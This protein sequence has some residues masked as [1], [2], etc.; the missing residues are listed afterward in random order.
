MSIYIIGIGGTGAKCVEAIAQLAA[1]GL[2][3]E[4]PL[5]VLFIDADETNGN[6]NR[7]RSSL[8]SYQRCY[9]LVSG[10]DKQ[11]CPWMKTPI[12]SFDLWSPFAEQS[13]NKELKTFFNYNTLKQNQPTLGNLFDVLYTKEEREANLDVGFRGRPAIGSAVMSQVDLD[14]L[15]QEPWGRFIQQIQTDTSSGKNPKVFLCGSIFGGTGASGLPTI[16]RLI[17]NKLKK[18]NIRD[19]VQ[20][21]CLFALPYFGFSATPDEDPNGIYAR[22]EQFLLNTEAALRYYVTQGQVIFDT[23]YLLGN[24]NFSTVKFSIG[25]NDQCNDPH[26]I[27]LY[28]GLA[29]RQFLLKPP[30]Q[31]GAVVLISRKNMGHLTWNDIPEQGEV[32]PN[33]VNAT[34]FAYTW[35]AEIAPELANAKQ[36]GV[37]RFQRLA[38]WLTKFFRPAKSQANLP[39]FSDLKQQEAIG[40]I[41]NWCE[42][43]LRW[44]TEIHKCTGDSIELFNVSAFDDLNSELKGEELPNL[45]IGDNRDKSRKSQD[46]PKKIKERLNPSVV[47]PPNQG[48]VGLA[49]AVYL[50]CKL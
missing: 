11:Q 50:L 1:I 2:F 25:K 38:P 40:I 31:K 8:S 16:A 21:G 6:L 9:E 22:S 4:Q 15:D 12:E 33:L 42:N 47:T 17:D 39:E 5:K 19:R 23:V 14:R 41:S 43:Y 3:N 37:D 28:A 7:A 34:R 29:A 13:F 49:K 20:I 36:Q 32:K 44:L 27:E 46:T 26:F 35:L 45:V 48:T 30:S 24:E 10:G 18:I